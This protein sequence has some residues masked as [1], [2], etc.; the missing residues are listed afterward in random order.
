MTHFKSKLVA[1]LNGKVE[2]G[3]IMNTLAHM[4]LGF[5]GSIDKE[6][7]KLMNYKDADGNDHENISGRPFIILKADN[8]NKIR[9]LRN[10]AIQHNLKF[11]DFT[12][13]MTEGTYEDQ[14]KRSSETK[15]ADLEYWGI[16]VFG[17]EAIGSELT[18]KFSLW[19]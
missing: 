14:I 19:K 2:A 18:R 3:K 11:V 12:N 8:S 7:L 1:V 17:D 5:G 13:T 4:S 16:I 6:R 15:E 10:A 9:T